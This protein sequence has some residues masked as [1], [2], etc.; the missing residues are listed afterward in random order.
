[1]EGIDTDL[2][3][4]MVSPFFSVV[5]PLTALIL[6]GAAL[7]DERRDKTLSFVVLRPISRLQ[8]AS[9]KTLAACGVSVGLALVGATALS[10]T[11]VVVS[12]HID[13]L[14]SIAAGAALGCILYSAVFV[15]LGNI[16]SGRTLIG[17]VYVLFVEN[18]LVDELPRV[19]SLSPWR[20]GLAATIDLAPQGFPARALLGT[21]GDLVPSASSALGATTATV[22][23]AVLICSVL[24]RR[25][26]SVRSRERS[27]RVY[28]PERL[29]WRW[30]W[31]SSPRPFSGPGKSSGP[32][33]HPE[34]RRR[35]RS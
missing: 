32:R 19:A 9:A 21:I 30:Y 33:G 15:L 5:V 23:V 11:Y 1:V 27:P 10:L 12:G 13:V 25:T 6:G 17:L 28:R 7:S 31:S 2:G 18:V 14:P 3:A 26:D 29:R 20:V 16:V 8:I 34:R 22:V 4:L 24:L 35:G